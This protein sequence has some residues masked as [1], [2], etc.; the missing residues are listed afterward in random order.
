MFK[1]CTFIF[2]F[3]LNAIFNTQTLFSQDDANLIDEVDITTFSHPDIVE[4]KRGGGWVFNHYS[5]GSDSSPINHLAAFTWSPI[6]SE[7][8][9]IYYAEVIDG[10]Y[11]TTGQLSMVLVQFDLTDLQGYKIHDARLVLRDNW[12]GSDNEFALE[13]SRILSG[14][15]W[16][17]YPNAD[18]AYGQEWADGRADFETPNGYRI[19]NPTID[20]ADSAAI[21]SVLDSGQWPAEIIQGS[22]WAFRNENRDPWT[23]A[24]PQGELG[25]IHEMKTW[26]QPD[27]RIRDVGGSESVS[28]SIADLVQGWVSGRYQN[29]GIV[30]HP[31]L[32]LTPIDLSLDSI[33]AS[34]IHGG[35]HN[36]NQGNILLAIDAEQV[37]P[38]ISE[39]FQDDA[40]TSVP[41]WFLY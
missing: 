35:W 13:I 5:D 12:N 7:A 10:D 8:K 34:N 6:G 22:C 39:P 31:S 38:P 41:E 25:M 17:P 33:E 19:E 27:G 40:S 4:A 30:I 9:I 18:P 2:L 28:S 24:T 37:D 29:N 23:P 15:E 11:V 26:N 14:P 3:V 16:M 20:L 32:T 36:Y 1:S 21:Q